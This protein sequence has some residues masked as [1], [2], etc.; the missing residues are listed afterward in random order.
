MG[1]GTIFL[2]SVKDSASNN[3]TEK[4]KDFF[5]HMGSSHANALG[6]RHSWA[7]IGVKGQEAF[8]EER[9][10][11]E[12]VGTGAILGYAR[13]VKHYKKHTKITGGSKIEVHSAGYNEGSI[14]RVLINEKEIYANSV[15][16]RG[17]NI[18][19][20]DFETH[21]KVFEAAYDTFKSAAEADRF[22]ADFKEKIP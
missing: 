16:K 7:F 9:S 10:E 6:F 4:L 13:K 5:A 18:V 20:L 8:T 14:A 11:D 12:P 3:M 2:V 15:A 17:I 21:K 22:V 19:A 1:P